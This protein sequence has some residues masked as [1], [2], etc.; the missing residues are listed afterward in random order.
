MHQ[1]FTTGE[2]TITDFTDENIVNMYDNGFVFTRKDK[3]VMNQTRS[4]RIDLSVFSL[5]SENRRVLRHTSDLTLKTIKLPIPISQYD[6]KI[7]K[8]AK[9]FYTEKFGEKLFS[10]NK[11]KEIL[12]DEN[13][14][15]FNTLI[16]Y[17]IMESSNATS[18][19]EEKDA[20]LLPLMGY[21]ICYENSSMLHYCYPFYDYMQYKNNYGL[22][23]MLNAIQLAKNYGLNYFYIGSATR[24][25]DK[26]KLDFN[27]LEWFD[28]QQWN[29][30]IEKVKALIS[31]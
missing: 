29:Q 12:T 2:I 15:N 11:I 18:N 4:L 9:D 22:S 7:Q 23:M 28:G 10:A 25:S 31:N 21:C 17:S 19:V 27:G 30:D 3:G 16:K 26:Y 24:P 8:M 6:Y 13:K 5:S 1:Y 20:D 14:S